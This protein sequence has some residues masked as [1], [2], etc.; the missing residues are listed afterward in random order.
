[1]I[2]WILTP[3]QKWLVKK[4]REAF[5]LDVEGILVGGMILK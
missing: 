2:G 1:M 3:T 4:F 5:L